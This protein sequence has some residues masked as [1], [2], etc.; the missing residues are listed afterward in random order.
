MG[1]EWCIM[2]I[3]E[4]SW[5]WKYHRVNWELVHFGEAKVHLLENQQVEEL[6]R[7]PS[8]TRINI[9]QNP[10][11]HAASWELLYYLYFPHLLTY[12]D[13]VSGKRLWHLPDVP[14]HFC[15]L[16]RG[17]WLEQLSWSTI[18]H[19]RE[20]DMAL[21]QRQERN[22]SIL[23]KKFVDPAPLSMHCCNLWYD[24]CIFPKS[25]SFVFASLGGLSLWSDRNLLS[26]DE[27]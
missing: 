21:C 24:L 4:Y 17:G 23:W 1:L 16:H 5:M 18:E 9:N 20:W 2:N 15:S 11:K 3:H 19:L 10:P 14:L 22:E 27:I 7:I 13:I 8:G 6:S 26:S 12:V 25:I